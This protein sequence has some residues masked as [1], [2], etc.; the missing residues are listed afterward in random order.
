VAKRAQ[1]RPLFLPQPEK[2]PRIQAV[3]GAG[4]ED[5][6]L[7]GG[8]RRLGKTKFLAVVT[9]HSCGDACHIVC[10]LYDGERKV[11]VDPGKPA[12][13]S[14]TVF[15]AE[16][17]ISI[18]D[19]FVPASGEGLIVNGVLYHLGRGQVAGADGAG[20]GGGWLGPVWHFL[21]C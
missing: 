21:S 9:N 19:A 8:A 18:Q 16:G 20:Q 3:P 5:E 15:P 2:L 6:D 14:T 17:V 10:Q 1:G 11:F 12:R 7:C 4:C 13:R